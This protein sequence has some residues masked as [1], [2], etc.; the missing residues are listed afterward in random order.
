LE[1]SAEKRD[2]AVGRP[3]G[4]IYGKYAVGA[5]PKGSRGINPGLMLRAFRM[6]LGWRLSGK[7]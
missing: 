5:A 6:V 1:D 2:Q 4:A 3:V 7:A